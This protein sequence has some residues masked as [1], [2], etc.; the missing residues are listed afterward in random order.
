MMTSKSIFPIYLYTLKTQ[1]NFLILLLYCSYMSTE[2][3][4]YIHMLY[5]WFFTI[6]KGN[7]FKFYFFL[8][9]RIS[10]VF[11]SRPFNCIISRSAGSVITLES[12]RQVPL[13]SCGTPGTKSVEKAAS[14]NTLRGVSKQTLCFL[15]SR[16]HLLPPKR[17]AQATARHSHLWKDC[18]IIYWTLWGMHSFVSCLYVFPPEDL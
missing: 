9:Q 11:L 6:S 12:I 1:S 13:Q 8:L 4:L 2:D 15:L 3:L 7:S 17:N 14:V 10:K 16:K 18:G 5:Y